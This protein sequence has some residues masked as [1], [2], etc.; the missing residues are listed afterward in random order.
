MIRTRKGHWYGR[1]AS[2]WAVVD[3]PIEGMGAV[4]GWK[5]WQPPPK[6]KP[7]KTKHG[8]RMD[9][10]VVALG[11]EMDREH[12]HGSATAPVRPIR[13]VSMGSGMGR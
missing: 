13:L 5:T 11:V 8:A 6:A 10:S 12:S 3:K 4:Q 7:P 9:P 2:T 1:Q